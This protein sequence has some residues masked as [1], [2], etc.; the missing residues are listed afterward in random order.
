M[1]KEVGG[2]GVRRIRDFNSAL[3]G[4]WCWRL[5]I[6]KASLWFRVLSARYGVEG[7][8]VRDGDR[9]ASLWWRDIIALRREEWFSEHVSRVVGNGRMIRFLTDVWVGGLSFR[10][11]FYRLFDLSLNKELSVFDIC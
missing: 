10:D 1:S 11:R 6:D 3:L 8:Q 2:M 9:T 5:L 4:K 7:G